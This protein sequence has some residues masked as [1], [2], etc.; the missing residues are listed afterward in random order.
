MITV[1]PS[2]RVVMLDTPADAA[3][4]LRVLRLLRAPAVDPKEGGSPVSATEIPTVEPY[5]QV[6]EER[7]SW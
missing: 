2:R 4:L 1:D 5:W 3:A 6:A 7:V